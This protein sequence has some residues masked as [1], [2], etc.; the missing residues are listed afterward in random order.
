M[1][2]KPTTS[3]TSNLFQATLLRFALLF[4]V[5]LGVAVL[6][7]CLGGVKVSFADLSEALKLLFTQPSRLDE[8]TGPVGMLLNLRLPRVLLAFV[9]GAALSLS[10][11][12]FQGLLRNPLADPYVVGISSGAA[13][14]ASFAI[15]MGLKATFAGLGVP[16]IAFCFALA[17]MLGVYSLAHLARGSFSESFLLVGVVTGTTLWALVMLLLSLSGR[18]LQEVIFWLMGTLS[19]ADFQLLGMATGVT[20]IGGAGL[21][22]LARDLNSL[23]FGEESAALMGSDVVRVRTWVIL[24]ASFLVGGAVSAAGIIGFVGLIVPHSARR[25]IGPDHR[26]L[27]PFSALLGGAFLAAADLLAR[28]LIPPNELPV[29][30]I[31]SLLG[32]PLFC[33]LLVRARR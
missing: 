27:L 5:A 32:G 29:G 23:A 22:Y 10:G 28:T 13:L 4:L 31:T 3:Q 19:T 25:L 15:V 30:V 1:S 26:V 21:L 9:V 8:A 2:A 6:G 7:L 33:Y 14:G 16:V 12:A 17:T 11:A 20:L 24:F 18:Y